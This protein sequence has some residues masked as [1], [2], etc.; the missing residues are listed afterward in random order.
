[1]GY[2]AG[3]TR[4]LAARVRTA[5]R[6]R[7]GLE[8]RLRGA[9]FEDIAAQLKLT[10][11]GAFRAYQRALRLTP[12]SPLTLKR[13]EQQQRLDRARTR[14]WPRFGSASNVKELAQLNREIV[15]LEQREAK[16]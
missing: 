13:K 14:L 15:R 4:S 7:Q 16:F 6:Q 10:I 5:E 1:M 3:D 9:S 11:S 8:L 2:M 12:E